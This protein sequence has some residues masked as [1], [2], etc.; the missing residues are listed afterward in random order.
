MKQVK[1]TGFIITT[2]FSMLFAACG[3]GNNDNPGAVTISI[4]PATENVAVGASKTFTV[5][6]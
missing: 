3:G 6:A 5:K 2:V 1:K 4:A